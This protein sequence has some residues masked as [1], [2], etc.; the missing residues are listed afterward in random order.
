MRTRRSGFTLVEVLVGLALTLFILAI[1][2]EAFSVGADT[3]HN[4]KSVGDMNDNLRVAA[5][6]LRAD[7][8]ANHF[9]GTRRLSDPGFWTTGS[10]SQGY[11]YYSQG[12]GAMAAYDNNNL[13][14]DA[15]GLT[16]RSQAAS[17][18]L[19][20]TVR[21]RGSLPQ[22]YFPGRVPG[23]SPLP[24]LGMGDTR[25]QQPPPAGSG[26][27]TFNSQWIEVCYFLAPVV[28]NPTAKGT[29]PLLGLYRQ[30]RLVVANVD[31]LNWGPLQQ[32]AS[33]FPQYAPNVSCQLNANAGTYVAGSPAFIYFNSPG[34][35]TIP[36]RRGA[37]NS[38]TGVPKFAPI[39]DPT[40]GLP[41]GEDLLIT[42]VISFDIQYIPTAYQPNPN[43][44]QPNQAAAIPFGDLSI[45]P[46]VFDTWSTRYDDLYDYSITSTT[47]TPLTAAQKLSIGALQITIR[48]WDPSTELTRQITIIQEM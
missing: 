4:L 37:F 31:S 35:L 47:T 6:A 15:F 26:W 19:A 11:F 14:V 25:F 39:T 30:Q 45:T 48:I 40:T 32:K 24:G 12:Q 10:P 13:S 33:F 20:F 16:L 21:A 36:N 9:E 5:N 23:G 29:T 18:N 7:L 41:T 3:F 8:S 43:T 1:L 42:G 22:Q 46:A 44:A 2:A 28:G 38:T 27:A 17:H 34:D